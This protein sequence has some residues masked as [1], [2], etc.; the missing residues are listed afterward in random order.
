MLQDPRETFIVP[1]VRGQ[2]HGAGQ[3]ILHPAP[4][5]GKI[6][7]VAYVAITLTYFAYRIPLW[8]AAHPL[9]SS[10]LLGAELFGTFTLFLHVYSTWCL[11]E[12]K[13]PAPPLGFE[14]DIFVTTW[15]ESVDILRYT[16]LAAKQVAYTRHIWLLDDGNRPEMAALAKELGVKYLTREDRCH[17]KAG[18]INH[19]L[20]HSNAEFIAIFD[21]DHAPSPDF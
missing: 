9:M 13:A 15:N 17:A 4:M 6:A 12:R 8:N 18:N 7:L 16:L 5:R 2:L 20:S 10:L 1:E 3:Q 21:C 11:V 14:A 19:A